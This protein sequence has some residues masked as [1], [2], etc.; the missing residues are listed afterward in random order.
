MEVAATYIAMPQ[1]SLNI[2]DTQYAIRI[3]KINGGTM[4]LSSSA[5]L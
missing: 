4:L 1:I 3:V 2:F 5:I